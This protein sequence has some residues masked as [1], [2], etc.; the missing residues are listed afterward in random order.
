MQAT[1]LGILVDEN[2]AAVLR[3]AYDVKDKP[4]NYLTAKKVEGTDAILEKLI[5]NSLIQKSIIKKY[6][7]YSISSKGIEVYSLIPEEMKKTAKKT[8]PAKSDEIAG[9]KV[10]L[11]SLDQKLDMIISLLQNGTRAGNGSRQANEVDLFKTRLVDEY[12]TLR[13]REFLS[14][15]KVWHDQLK[16]I[17]MDRYG[18]KDYEYD[19]LLQRLK[20]TNLGIVSMSQG[21]DKTW[22]EIRA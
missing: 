7:R 13:A 16:H 21:K 17:I 9:L 11:D 15:G 3:M 22:I 5:K 20:E 6:V 1:V 18:Y 10:T 2:D 12:R 8:K 19:E 4:K 14:D